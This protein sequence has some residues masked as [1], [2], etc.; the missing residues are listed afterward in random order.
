[1]ASAVYIHIP[2]CHKI[3]SY[4]DFPKVFYNDDWSSKYLEVLALEIDNRY[5]GEEV[6]TIYIGGGTPSVLGMKELKKLFAIV[7]RF[8]RSKDCEITF[9]INFDSIDEDKLVFLKKQGV[10]RLS[11]GIE[12]TNKNHQRL[13]NRIEDLEGEKEIIKSARNLGFNNINVDLIYALPDETLKELKEDLRYI[14]SLDVDHISTYS[15]IIEEHTMLYIDGYTNISE[16]LDLEMYE[17]ICR[18]LKKNGFGHYE[19]SNFAKEGHE[20]KHNLVYWNNEEYYGF[21]LGSASYLD[22]KRF[23]NTKSFTKYLAGEFILSEEVLSLDDKLEYEVLLSLRK[24]TG[25]NKGIF[26]DKK[27]NQNQLSK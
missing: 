21:G 22:N 6:K 25:I 27:D 1:M 4:C 3:C 5:R 12:T 24:T 16:E 13:L 19:I 2:F 10:N 9:E 18:E 23:V 8:K 26:K 7:K 14:I 17:Y 15:L 20:S 11:F